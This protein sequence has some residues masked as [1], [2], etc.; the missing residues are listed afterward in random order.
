MGSAHR[1]VTNLAYIWGLVFT[2][3]ILSNPSSEEHFSELL[4]ICARI[5]V[6]RGSGRLDVG[7]SHLQ[8]HWSVFDRTF[9]S[10]RTIERFHI[11]APLELPPPHRTNV[12]QPDLCLTLHLG[13]GQM[14]LFPS[15]EKNIRLYKIFF[16]IKISPSTSLGSLKL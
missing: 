14:Q 9:P 13:S 1:N 8:S 12:T 2:A 7:E 11:P 4:A 16:Y 6:L 15:V 5:L 10:P 3:F